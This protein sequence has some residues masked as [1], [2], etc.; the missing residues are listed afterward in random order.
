MLKNSKGKLKK[1]LKRKKKGTRRKYFN[2]CNKLN[3]IFIE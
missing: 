2:T 3:V 1:I